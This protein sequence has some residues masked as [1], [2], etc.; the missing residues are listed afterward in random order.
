MSKFIQPVSMRVTREQYEKDLRKPLLSMGYEEAVITSFSNTPILVNNYGGKN[1]IL[2]NTNGEAAK[3]ENRHFIPNYNPEYFLAVAAMTN[4]ELGIVGEWWKCV[5]NYSEQ[6]TTNKLYKCE[7]FRGDTPDFIDDEGD[8]NGYYGRELHLLNLKKAT[9]SDLIA[10]FEPKIN[11]NNTSTMTELTQ[12]EKDTLAKLITKDNE[13]IFE[14]LGIKKDK[15]PIKV[16]QSKEDFKEE[17]LNYLTIAHHSARAIGKSELIRRVIVV[18]GKY[19]NKYKF[20]LHEKDGLQV[21][22][23]T[24]K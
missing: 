1:G 15:N 19:Q 3:I 7:R 5:V 8:L 23:I 6:F 17:M 4:E 9:L 20:I 2:S 16:M 18:H 12:Q 11:T 24:E 14:K 21:L 13:A 22:E 10:H